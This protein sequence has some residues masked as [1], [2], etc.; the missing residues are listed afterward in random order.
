MNII[1]IGFRGC[2][3]STISK[4]LA[5]ELNYKYFSTDKEIKKLHN[6][7]IS[8][9]VEEKGWEYFRECESKIIMGLKELKDHI[10]DTGGGSILT[11]TNRENIK[12]A[13]SV[14][15]LEADFVDIFKR[16]EHGKDRPKLTNKKDLEEEI[17]ALLEE[18]KEKYLSI[19]DFTINTS[20][21]SMEEC[22]RAIIKNLNLK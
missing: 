2:G 10:I 1:L 20:G 12:K 7:S 6:K 3:K 14:V 16:I 17:K 11:E 19:A 15:Y 5:K 8:K 21:H 13:G 9:I 22:T 4:A 18:R